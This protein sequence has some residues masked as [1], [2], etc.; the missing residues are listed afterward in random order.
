MGLKRIVDIANKLS[1][2]EEALIPY[3][4]YKAKVDT[5]KLSS[6]PRDSKLILV[7]AITPTKAGEGKTTCS[8]SL[9]DGLNLLGESVSLAL[10][11]P[12][13]GPVFGVKGGAAGGGKVTVEPSEDINLH[14]NGDMHAL[15]TANNLISAIIDNHI[16]QGNELNIDPDR[17]LFS[18]VMDMNDRALREIEIAHG[19]GN[20]VI[21]RDSFMITVASELMAILC[22]AKDQEDFID[23]LNKIIVAY[24]KDGGIVR[25]KDLRITKALMKLLVDALKPN[26]VQTAFGTPAFIHGGPFANIAHGCNSIIATKTALSLSDYVV[27]EAGFGSDLGAQK[28]LD[29]KCREA[30]L[31]PAL[32][33]MVA[34]IRALKCHGGALDLSE[35]NLPALKEGLLNLEVHVNNM[36]SYNKPVVIAINHFASDTKYEIQALEDWCRL[37]NLPFAFTDGFLNGARGSLE[38]ARLVKHTIETSPKTELIHSY[39]LSDP[40]KTKIEK[41]ATKI[42][43]AK[44]VEYSSEA[45]KELEEYQKLGVDHFNICIAKTPQSLSDNPKLL[46]APKDHVLH[47]RSVKISAGAGF[48]VLITGKILTMPGLPKVPSA[49]KMEDE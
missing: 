10:R 13:L 2:P 47:V 38:L 7:T 22:L 5:T 42:Y 24:N 23:R 14:F 26:L 40:I 28:F 6:S 30:N 1:I 17:V 15:T 16:F 45:L 34:T 31:N 49:V 41:I 8:I 27:T 43:H 4:Y 35:E 32:I 25:V 33:V 12:S 19:K 21:R 20:G 11:E 18:R 46:N 44:A 36:K 39:E 37:K 29:I 48:L 3:G 9:A